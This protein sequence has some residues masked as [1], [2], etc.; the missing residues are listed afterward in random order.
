ML[1]VFRAIHTGIFAARIGACL[2]DLGIDVIRLN[3][4]CKAF[5]FE[6]ECKK[7]REMSPQEAALYFLCSALPDIEPSCFLLPMSS[8][9]I[10]QRAAVI[11]SQWVSNGKMRQ[12]V[13]D[14]I[15]VSFRRQM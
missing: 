6:V 3:K 5:L 7:F 12:T 4:Q 8:R 9:D 15:L 14:G 2:N 1:G 11:S 13:L 10:A